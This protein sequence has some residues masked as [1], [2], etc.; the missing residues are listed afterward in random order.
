[1]DR[2]AFSTIGYFRIQADA[3]MCL[4]SR[5]SDLGRFGRRLLRR[6]QALVIVLSNSWFKEY[7]I[8]PGLC[9]TGTNHLVSFSFI[10]STPQNICIHRIGQTL[11]DI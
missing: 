11:S 8:L 3:G 1:M 4:E 9:P 10:G 5:S 2:R 6:W 7:D